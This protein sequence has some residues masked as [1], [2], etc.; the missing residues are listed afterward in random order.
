M[1]LPAAPLG[2]PHAACLLASATPLVAALACSGA[3]LTNDLPKYEQ[4]DVPTKVL[5]ILT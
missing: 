3:P 5:A 2:C 1:L 4:K